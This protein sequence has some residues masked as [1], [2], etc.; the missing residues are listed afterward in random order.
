MKWCHLISFG[1][2]CLATASFASGQP[3]NGC[4]DLKEYTHPHLLVEVEP[5][6]RLDVFCTGSGSPTVI[7]EAGGGDDSSSFRAVQPGL[8]RV[9]R[10]CSYDRAGI[11]FSD[12]A[13]W[14]STAVNTVAD[15]HRLVQAISPGHAV[16]LVGHSDG[17]LYVS[18]YAATYPEDV[19]GLVLID[20]FTVG[21]DKLAAAV[22]TRR[23]RDAWYASDNRDIADARKCVELAQSGALA[24][25]ESKTSTCLDN[26][27]SPD[28]ARHKIL[29]EQLARASE[30]NAL[31]S[32]LVDTYPTPDHGMSPA[33]LVLQKANPSFGMMPLV[34]LT[35]GKDEQTALPRQTRIAIARAW[36]KNNDQLA[37]RSGRGRNIV[38]PNAHHYIQKEQPDAVIDAADQ[39]IVEVRSQAGQP[40]G[41]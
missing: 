38:I 12:Q 25:P 14:P 18:L 39:V 9:T 23:Q 32:A 15:L 40:S 10:T 7:F 13:P 16:I 20:P 37:A 6:R 8:S 28:I 36:K 1:L 35:A 29:N 5:G 30:Q 26:P 31:L 17:G 24:K 21:A 33:E 22:L 2:A 34:V 11:G 19:A 41:L 27:A 3:A 4:V